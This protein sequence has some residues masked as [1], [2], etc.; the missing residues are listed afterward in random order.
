VQGPVNDPGFPPG[1]NARPAEV[2]AP[3]DSSGSPTA[4]A[5]ALAAGGGGGRGGRGGG[6]GGGGGGRGGANETVDTG[7]YR[8]VLDIG[9]TKQTTVLRVVRVAPGQVSVMDG[10]GG[11]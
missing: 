7:D 11:R 8:V 9:G 6:G 1:Y 4:Q 10:V 2:R 3:A 5:R